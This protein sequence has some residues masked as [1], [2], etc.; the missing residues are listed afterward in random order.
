MAILSVQ[1]SWQKNLRQTREAESFNANQS[2]KTLLEE[3]RGAKDR[4]P[5]QAMAAGSADQLVTLQ[6]QLR[7]EVASIAAQRAD[8]ETKRDHAQSDLE[9]LFADL[10]KSEKLTTQFQKPAITNANVPLFQPT[11]NALSR[12]FTI[13]PIKEETPLVL[14]QGQDLLS[15]ARDTIAASRT[16]TLA[17]TDD[18][19][20]V[21]I[22]KRKVG[23]PRLSD[24]PVTVHF[25]V[26]DILKEEGVDLSE[27]DSTNAPGITMALKALLR[28][29][30]GIAEP[31]I[32][33]MEQALR[34][35][36]RGDYKV[37][38]DNRRT[39]LVLDGLA[40]PKLAPVDIAVTD[41]PDPLTVSI[42]E[43]APVT[44]A[45]GRDAQPFDPKP[46][47]LKPVFVIEDDDPLAM[48]FTKI[49]KNGYLVITEPGYLAAAISGKS[50]EKKGRISTADQRSAMTTLDANITNLVDQGRKFGL[51]TLG[52]L[53]NSD[54]IKMPD[55]MRSFFREKCPQA[56]IG[57]LAIIDGQIRAGYH[58]EK[59]KTLDQLA[60]KIQKMKLSGK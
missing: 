22:Q 17:P 53:A 5:D 38:L 45:V 43:I 2:L 49:A 57:N 42:E 4:F 9:V 20:T 31:T 12:L 3:E 13:S 41:E 11:I 58:Q 56:L 7:N 16:R 48:I 36:V 35:I 51:S 33:E 25:K 23:R 26:S 14:S 1:M 52:D 44:K 30:V 54:R 29:D 55:Q 18:L 59:A 24:A 34:G 46:K 21:E 28:N 39:L 32:E 8:L 15:A 40:K 60:L 19:I 6:Q 47:E 27:L 50:T 10:E 37:L